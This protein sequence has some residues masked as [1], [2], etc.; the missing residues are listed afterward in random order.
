MT[1]TCIGISTVLTLNR[2]AAKLI[3]R[4]IR[5][6]IEIPIIWNYI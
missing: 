1:T 3:V 5:F 2:Q 6:N 4:R